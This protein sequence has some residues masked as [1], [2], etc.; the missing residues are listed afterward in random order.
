MA[1]KVSV[2]KE[3]SSII[4]TGSAVGKSHDVRFNEWEGWLL[5]DKNKILGFEGKIK[6][7]SVNTGIPNLDNHLK[8]DDFFDIENYP[9]ISFSGKVDEKSKNTMKGKL[10]FRGVTKEISFPVKATDN[11]IHAEFKLD[12]IPYKMRYLDIN[13][14]IKVRFDFYR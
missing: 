2:D 8:S 10:I 3:K 13:K 7:D 14:E 1:N 5:V 9:K 6:A 4:F 11:S 12:I